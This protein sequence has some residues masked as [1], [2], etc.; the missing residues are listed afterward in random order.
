MINFFLPKHSGKANLGIGSNRNF[1][2]QIF[3]MICLSDINDIKKKL[4]Y[5]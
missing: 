4:K 3:I 5:L 1:I 2:H